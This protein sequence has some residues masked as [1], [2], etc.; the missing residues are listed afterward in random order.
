M[1]QILWALLTLILVF[2]GH[3][4]EI[5]FLQAPENQQLYARDTTNSAEVFLEGEFKEKAKS[6]YIVLK[7]FKNDKLFASQKSRI[8]KN[9]FAISTKIEA[10]LH[11]YRF[12]LYI[13]NKKQE[14]LCFVADDVVCGDAYIITGQS[15]SHA[16]STLSTYSNPFCR[17]FGVKT[18][19]KS[20]TEAHKKIRWGLATGNCPDLKREIGGWFTVNPL[21]VG[22][23][24]MELMRLLVEK[25]QMPVCIINGGSGSSSI[26]QNMKKTSK[27]TLD[28]SFGRLAYRVEQAGLKNKI[29]AIFWHQGESNSNT[30]KSYKAYAANF[31]TLL[32]DWKK[33]YNS[34][35]KIY[36]FQLHPGCGKQAVSFHAE[37]REVQNQLVEKYDML[38][39]MSTLGV[40]GHD[41]CHF[42]YKGYLEFANRIFPLVSRD[43]YGVKVTHTITPPTLLEASYK[44]PK[45]IV[46]SFD[47]P[48]YLEEKKE[49]NGVRYFLKD[50]FFFS[51]EQGKTNAI[52]KVENIKVVGNTLIISLVYDATYKYISYLPGKFYTGTKVIYNGPWLFGKENNIGALSFYQR[53][54][55]TIEKKIVQKKQNDFKGFQMIT[56]ALNG[57]NYKVVLPKKANKNRDWIW[58]ARFWG[59]EPQTDIALLE[60]GFHLVYIEVAGLFGNEKALRIWDDFYGLMTTKYQLNSKVVLEGMSR[61]GLIVFNWANKNA[62]K[63]ACMYVDAPVCDFKSWPAGKGLGEGSAGAWKSC[64]KVYGFSEEEAM[65]YKGNPVDHLENIA[66]NKVPVLSVVGNADKV[67]PVSENSLLVQ[68]KLQQLGWDATII[69]KPGIGH[70]PHSLKDPKPIVDFIL[71]HTGNSIK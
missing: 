56:A 4:Q 46:L 19:Y 25:H 21:G 20:Y 15:N 39:I 2:N 5:N 55:K 36:L 47:Q 31:D 9:K 58:R 64:L 63:V 16:S 1:K 30:E 41:G 14:K 26:E 24:G 38:E 32:T 7:V 10:G 51:N 48:L 3:S 54:I 22:V 59:H 6:K 33:E 71:E 34:L 8:K 43:F 66:L 52:E 53:P 44:S 70:H 18:G 29:K 60:K 42:S 61:G 57:V 67:V 37:L 11:Q 13:K 23:W 45:Q 68:K 69:G 50:Q 40:P 65:G 35:E 27:P 49:V 12:E 62:S 28:T 17:S